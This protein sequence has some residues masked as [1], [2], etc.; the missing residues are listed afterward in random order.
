M[1]AAALG[2]L[3]SLTLGGAAPEPAPGGRVALIRVEGQSD[4]R[5][6]TRLSAELRAQRFD[7]VEL[8]RGLDG[9]APERLLSDALQDARADAAVLVEPT[10]AAIRV[11]IANGLTGKQIFREVALEEHAVPDRALVALWTVELLRASAIAPR[12]PAAVVAAPP[13]PPPQPELAGVALAVA[14]AATL[15]PGGL[16]TSWHLAVGAR[17]QGWRRGGLEALA[18][19]PVLPA[20]VAHE[21]GAAIVS[22]GLL[23]VGAF[24]ATGGREAR[25]SAQAALGAALL[26]TRATGDTTEVYEGSTETAA[27]G[28][29]YLRAGAS[30][31]ATEWFRARVDAVSGVM[32]PRPVVEFDGTRVAAWGRPWLAVLLGGE[33]TF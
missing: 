26:L 16:G 2:V 23:G 22:L 4:D 7:V 19:V 17:W 10:P 30:L 33:A 27:S 29:P 9:A 8:V 18:L 12:A 24:A 31:R 13:S 20:R 25:W 21:G 32:F 3:L 6:Q 5:L 14:P 15:S 28:G 11:W 1:T